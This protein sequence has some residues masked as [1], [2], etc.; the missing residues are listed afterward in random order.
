MEHRG[1]VHRGF[2]PSPHSFIPQTH[3]WAFDT[4]LLSWWKAKGKLLQQCDKGSSVGPIETDMFTHGVHNAETAVHRSRQ[5]DLCLTR[6]AQQEREPCRD[7]K[8]IQ[9]FPWVPPANLKIALAG[10]LF[11][12]SVLSSVPYHWIRLS[13]VGTQRSAHDSFHTEV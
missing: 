1:P 12:E 4:V 5:H 10:T 7:Q 6:R 11:P 3:K 9:M 2:P 13:G 8:E